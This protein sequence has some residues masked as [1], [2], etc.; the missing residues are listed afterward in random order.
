MQAAILGLL[1]QRGTSWRNCR[2]TFIQKILSKKKFFQESKGD[3]RGRWRDSMAERRATTTLAFDTNP[4]GEH[5]LTLEGREIDRN[6][7][8]GGGRKGKKVSFLGRLIPATPRRELRGNEFKVGK[9]PKKRK[10][11]AAPEHSN[12]I[13][14]EL[15]AK[16]TKNWLGWQ[17]TK[18]KGFRS[19]KLRATDG[20]DV[21]WCWEEKKRPDNQ[22]SFRGTN[23]DKWPR[24]DR[25]LQRWKGTLRD[26]YRAIAKFELKEI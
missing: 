13:K 20:N 4:L 17:E 16:Q 14:E 19:T 18:K 8:R 3:L 7:R 21:R 22:C 26:P 10:K 24:I 11:T 2:K 23:F 9:I 15:N 1:S 25:L 12:E 5:F 6:A